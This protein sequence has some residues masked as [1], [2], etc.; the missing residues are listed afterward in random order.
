MEFEEIKTIYDKCPIVLIDNSGSTD[1]LMCE[2]TNVL[3]YELKVAKDHFESIGV[4]KIYLMFWNSSASIYSMEPIDVS[5]LNTLEVKSKGSTNLVPALTNIPELWIE[6]KNTI[7][8]Y[9]YTD[10]E[11]VDGNSIKTHI[12]KCTNIYNYGGTKFKRLC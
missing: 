2:K 12:K 6:N 11:I 1:D 7:D 10:G 8:L 5:N 4:E 3:A 9:I